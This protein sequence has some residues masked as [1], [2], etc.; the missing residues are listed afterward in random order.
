MTTRIMLAPWNKWDLSWKFFSISFVLH[1]W[2]LFFS[3]IN[4]TSSQFLLFCGSRIH[5]TMT[6]GDHRLR[7]L[8]LLERQQTFIF[9]YLCVNIHRMII[10]ECSGTCLRLWIWSFF[11]Y[12]YCFF[13]VFQLNL[14]QSL[15]F[16]QEEQ[17]IK[18]ISSK[19]KWRDIN[20]LSVEQHVCHQQKSLFNTSGTLLGILIFASMRTQLSA[21]QLSVH[22]SELLEWTSIQLYKFREKI[23]SL[24]KW[25]QC[26]CNFSEK[27]C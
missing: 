22:T 4:K 21:S 2:V 12:Y 18:T 13:T 24:C 5:L 14:Q 10:F 11:Y 19:Y 20:T 6:N 27:L 7:I 17:E 26:L 9:G 25:S 3:S 15:T 8:Q 23:H 1:W 16:R